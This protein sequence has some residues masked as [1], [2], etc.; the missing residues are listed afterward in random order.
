LTTYTSEIVFVHTVEDLD[1][2]DVEAASRAE[3]EAVA[4]VLFRRESYPTL[5]DVAIVSVTAQ[6]LP[7]RRYALNLTSDA[8]DLD[9]AEVS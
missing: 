7:E 8:E 4:A 5:R 9:L 2:R 3:A 1:W 6:E